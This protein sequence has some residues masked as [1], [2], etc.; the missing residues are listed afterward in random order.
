M[1]NVVPPG[2]FPWPVL[3][4][5]AVY[6]P[7]SFMAFFGCKKEERRQVVTTVRLIRFGFVAI[8]VVGMVRIFGY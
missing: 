8:L 6:L 2:D 5:S 1:P 7:G 3:L 4:G